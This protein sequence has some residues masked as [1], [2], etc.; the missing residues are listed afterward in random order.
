MTN[1]VESI[2]MALRIAGASMI[3]SAAPSEEESETLRNLG[4]KVA[5]NEH[6]Q[7]EATNTGEP[8]EYFKISE[9]A[10]K[11]CGTGTV[12][13]KVH[14]ALNLA[15][16]IAGV[17]FVIT[18]GYR[19]KKHNTEVGGV[20]NSSHTKRYAVDIACSESRERFKIIGGLIHAGFNRIGI[21]ENFIH[22]DMDPNKDSEVIWLY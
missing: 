10:C 7:L 11:C 16:A 2:F 17:P 3:L 12:N 13:S 5:D 9:F 19:C 1:Y 21:A 14:K 15:R 6:G 20:E 18:S 8:K 22:T 4:I